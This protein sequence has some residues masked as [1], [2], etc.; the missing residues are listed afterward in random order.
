MEP[1][2]IYKKNYHI[3]LRDVDLKKELRLSTLFGYFQDVANLA[4]EN[5]GASIQDL[6]QKYGVAW[7]LM[8]I[9]VDVIRNPKLDEEITIET[10]PLEPGKLEFERDFLV[11]DQ[12]G[13]IIA[14][15]VSV[16]V[17]MD[18]AKRRL[19][20]SDTIS[21]QY[22]YVVT[23]RAMDITLGKLKGSEN[24][25]TAYLKTIGYSDIDFNGHL[26]NSRYV[27]YMMDCFSVEEHQVYHISS[28]EVNYLN[29]V[30]PGDTLVL[31]KD[32]S[33]VENQMIYIEGLRKRDEKIVF[34]SKVKIASN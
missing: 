20:R 32:L 29:E 26:N 34:R 30:L 2:M 6:E 3:D 5:L 12:Q 28:I 17:V 21:L 1:S 11:R 24:L 22:P 18:I 15:A 8:Q 16:W 10:W 23:E 13:E 9:R 33:S 4:A 7:I 25:D 14:R 31:K 19:K 27:D